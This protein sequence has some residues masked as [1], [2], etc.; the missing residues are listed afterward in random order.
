MSVSIFSLCILTLSAQNFRIRG[1]VSETGQDVPIPYAN[2]VLQLPDSTFVNG[3]TSNTKGEF[4]LSRIPA[5]SYRLIVSCMGYESTLIVLDNL[6]RN[7]EIGQIQLSENSHTLDEVTISAE[8]VVTRIDRQIVLPSPT[9]IQASNTGYELLNRLMLPGIQVNEMQ[10]SISSLY[11]GS[12][13]VRINDVKVSTAEILALRPHE[14]VRIEYIDNPGIRYADEGVS[15]VIN[16][17]VKRQSSGVSG[18]INLNNAFTTGMGNDNIYIKANNKR[19]EFGLNYYMSYRDYSQRRVDQQQQFVLADGSIRQRYRKGSNTPF[20]YTS[21]DV[22]VSYNFTEPD[23]HVFNAVM[24]G[25]FYNSQRRG[26][27]QTVY[28]TGLPDLT[29][30]QDPKNKTYTPAIDLYYQATLPRKQWLAVNIVGTH[31]ID[32]YKHNY[33]EYSDEFTHPDSEYRY[34]TDGRKYSL[35]GEGIYDKEFSHFKFTSGI[36][37]T[38]SYTRNEY[39][40]DT[41]A[42]TGMHNSN[43][44]L[45]A[46]IQGKLSKLDYSLGVGGSRQTFDQDDKGYTYYTFRPVASLSHPLWKGASLRYNF[47][48]TPALPSLSNLSGIRQQANEIEV[49]VGNP[50]L[51]PYRSYINQLQFN[52]QIPRLTMRFGAL[53]NYRRNPIMGEVRRI[54]YTDG[55]YLFEYHVNNQRSLSQFNSNGYLQYQVIPDLLSVSTYAA[56]SRYISRGNTYN[57]YYSNWFY[58]GNINFTKGNWAAFAYIGNRYNSLFG[59]NI[60]YGEASSG[61]NVNYRIKDIRLGGGMWYPFQARGWVGRGRKISDLVK[62]SSTTYIRNNGNMVTLSFSWNFNYGREHQAG[63]KKLNNADYDSGVVK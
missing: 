51:T 26:F 19:S 39:T 40:G 14:V 48:I 16:F 57:H 33:I 60:Y 36:Q 7:I 46:Q 63:Q 27:R 23:K 45:Y 9:Q 8:R 28:E 61:F 30:F 47:R 12:V 55:S 21:Q 59:E 3:A 6:N 20:N 42:L 56:F 62:E 10:N 29:T 13:Q 1:T 34:A 5:G 15:A 31:I 43:A 25:N 54:D 38:Q 2:I 50:D 35:I 41:E 24:R 18:G 4:V 49:N 53:Y 37:Y 52:Y 22:E 44:Y 32:D 58:N 17:I 11:G